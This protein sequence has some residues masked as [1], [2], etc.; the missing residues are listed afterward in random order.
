MSPWSG[1]R[2]LWLKLRPGRAA[3]RKTRAFPVQ[4]RYT[5]DIVERAFRAGPRF[6][7]AA[8]I[9]TAGIRKGGALDVF[10]ARPAARHPVQDPGRVPRDARPPT[11]PR[12]GSEVVGPG[13]RRMRLAA[14]SAGLDR[15]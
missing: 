11:D 7:S 3:W 12:P 4:K 14:G 6:A 2:S 15:L 1:Q 5:R 9:P 13:P 10:S 8:V